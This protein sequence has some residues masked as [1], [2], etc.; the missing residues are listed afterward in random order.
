MFNAR[1]FVFRMISYHKDKS[2]AVKRNL[3]LPVIDTKLVVTKLTITTAL[4]NYNNANTYITYLYYTL[5]TYITHLTA[6]PCR[7]LRIIN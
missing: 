7:P 5:V 1:F 3:Y 2:T 6:V 4:I